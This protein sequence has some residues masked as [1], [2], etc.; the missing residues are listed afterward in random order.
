MRR[1]L[2][3]LMIIFPLLTGCGENK[4]IG[5]SADELALNIRTEYMGMT[6]FSANAEV[7][8]DYGQRV[9][10]Y[11]L[12]VQWQKEGETV[13]TVLAPENIAGITA[14]IE[15]GTSFLDYDGI[16]METGI[17]SQDGFSPMEAIPVLM[18]YIL[19]GYIAQCAYDGSETQNLLWVSCRE[20]ENSPGK[21]TEAELWFDVETHALTQAEILYDGYTVIQCIFSDFTKE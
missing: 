5:S 4:N 17:L 7:I 20:P 16:S 8:A 3:A 14:R 21:G 2:C 13:L 11:T 9:Y 12:D 1:K 15:S 19:S 10:E 18:N 6:G